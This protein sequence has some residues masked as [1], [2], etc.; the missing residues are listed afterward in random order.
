MASKE[1]KKR[2]IDEISEENALFSNIDER[3][4]NALK[5]RNELREQ[6]HATE[7]TK[8]R[9]EV[10]SGYNDMKDRFEKMMD[11]MFDSFEKDKEFVIVDK[12]IT[13]AAYIVDKI[14]S[15]HANDVFYKLYEHFKNLSN[16]KDRIDCMCDGILPSMGSTK[17]LTGLAGGIAICLYEF[18]KE[19]NKN[20][21][22]KEGKL[23]WRCSDVTGHVYLRL[24]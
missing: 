6:K 1:S 23:G 5:K 13:N 15:E 10:E 21:T 17:T 7:K 14:H 9:Q 4:E 8:L 12:M 22:R 20:R 2:A 24:Y 3:I 19:F 11:K 16:T 18:R